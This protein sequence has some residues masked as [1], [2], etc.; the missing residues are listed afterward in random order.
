MLKLWIRFTSIVNELRTLKATKPKPTERQVFLE[1]ER[2][3]YKLRIAIEKGKQETLEGQI[4][5]LNKAQSQLTENTYDEAIMQN[6]VDDYV[7]TIERIKGE[8]QESKSHGVTLRDDHASTVQR[9]KDKMEEQ[10]T[11]FNLKKCEIES[12]LRQQFEAT[13]MK[14]IDMVKATG[15]EEGEAKARQELQPEIDILKQELKIAAEKHPLPP[16]PP[17][18]KQVTVDYDEMANL[19]M[20]NESL[21][22]INNQLK[23]QIP[24]VGTVMNSPAQFQTSAEQT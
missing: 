6:N 7:I 12:N 17:T 2:N 23:K 3:A 10:D 22:N 4:D 16:E 21:M 15:V 8:L 20:R 5:R 1:K 14:N 13:L 18:K 24:A 9:L 11:E 19:R